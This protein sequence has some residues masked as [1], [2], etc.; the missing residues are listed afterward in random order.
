M[1]ISVIIPTLRCKG[2]DITFTSLGRQTFNSDN[3][4]LI[5]IDD[6]LEDRKHEYDYYA[7]KY[8]IKNFLYLRPKIGYWRSNIPRSNSRNTGLVHANG[9]LIVFIDDYTW[10]L[11]KFLEQHWKVYNDGYCMVGKANVVQY[12]NEEER[13]EKLLDSID[14]IGI[15]VVDTKLDISSSDYSIFMKN[16]VLF[17]VGDTRGDNDVK[18]CGG[19]WFY[20]CNS[21][22]PLTKIIEVNGF[23]EEF[24]LALEEDIGLG[25]M[26]ERIGCKFYY[27]ICPDCTAYH[28]D[29]THIDKIMK[30]KNLKRLKYKNITY[31]ELRRRSTIDSNPDEIQVVLKEKYGTRYDGAWGLHEHRMRVKL[32][33]ANI[34][35][36][37]KIFDLREERKR[38]GK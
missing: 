10:V 9:E 32:S 8:A 17:N 15:P 11:P 13:K 14:K 12:I 27:K 20:T 25:L 3:W 24:D 7:N 23:D 6:F 18:N 38:I 21:S 35:N 31:E 1:Q 28:M 29:H 36:G 5:V 30:N 37:D 33:Y 16:I 22:I 4:E 34:V 19:G 2:L 26:L